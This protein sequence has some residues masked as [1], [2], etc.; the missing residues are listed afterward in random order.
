MLDLPRY[1]NP[2]YVMS[3][4]WGYAAHG[5]W[6]VREIWKRDR[7][8]VFLDASHGRIAYA[9]LLTHN[10]LPEWVK[11]EQ[12]RLPSLENQDGYWLWSEDENNPSAPAVFLLDLA[13]RSEAIN[14]TLDALTIYNDET[15]IRRSL[16]RRLGI[17]S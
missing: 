14:A 15:V 17:R 16:E 1:E 2:D 7:T 4:A 9:L 5:I 6:D 13:K 8:Q 10:E 3:D 12:G 11:D